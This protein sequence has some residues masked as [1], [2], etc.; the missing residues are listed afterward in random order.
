LE[1]VPVQHK[2]CFK[3]VTGFLKIS[4]ALHTRLA[5]VTDRAV[6]EL[7][8]V[9]VNREAFLALRKGTRMPVVSKKHE[10]YFKPE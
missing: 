8:H 9:A 5:A 6:G 3:E 10:Q 2:I 4:V 7:L 1:K